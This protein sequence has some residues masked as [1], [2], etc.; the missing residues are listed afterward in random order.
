MLDYTWTAESLRSM[1][2]FYVVLIRLETHPGARGGP[3]SNPGAAQSHLSSCFRAPG[4]GAFGVSG[5][6][7]FTNCL[8]PATVTLRPKLN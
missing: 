2:G 6:F 1:L 3:G 8:Y 7:P 5:G 4:N